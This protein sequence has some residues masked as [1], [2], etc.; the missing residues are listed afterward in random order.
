MAYI[1]KVAEE[2]AKRTRKQAVA[3][4][5]IATMTTKSVWIAD[6]IAGSLACIA[7]LHV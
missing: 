6:F 3:M 1:S 7:A 2:S 4:Q 5:I